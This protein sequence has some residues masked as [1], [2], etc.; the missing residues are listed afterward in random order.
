MF[1]VGV[2]GVGVGGV[3]V[4]F[5]VGKVSLESESES[6]DRR[7]HIPGYLCYCLQWIRGIQTLCFV[8]EC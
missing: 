4:G 8:Q 7:L 3:G 6:P 1:G 2:A 5:G